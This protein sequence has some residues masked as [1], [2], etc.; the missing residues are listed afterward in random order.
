VLVRAALI[1]GGRGRGKDVEQFLRHS[2][3]KDIGERDYLRAIIRA[4][5]TPGV[6]AP[7]IER[8]M[9]HMRRFLRWRVEH[10]DASL[11]EDVAFLRVEGDERYHSAKAVFLDRPYVLSGLS[12]IYDGRIKGR[13]RRPL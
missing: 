7:T 12:L 2:G 3:V 4:N 1:R 9:Q 5:Y 11:L 8:H 10:D 13:D 6:P